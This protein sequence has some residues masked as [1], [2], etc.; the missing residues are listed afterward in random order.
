MKLFD[1]LPI[2]GY[3]IGI[4]NWFLPAIMLIWKDKISID[5]LSKRQSNLKWHNPWVTYIIQFLNIILFFLL[6]VS[7]LNTIVEKN[8]SIIWF[9]AFVGLLNGLFSVFTGVSIYPTRSI[10]THHFNEGKYSRLTGILQVLISTILIILGIV[11][12]YFD[13]N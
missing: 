6:F 11:L 9:V 1:I 12:F 7:P 8:I 4:S 10:F 2:S 13:A 3:I 5:Q